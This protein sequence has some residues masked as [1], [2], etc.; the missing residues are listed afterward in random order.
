MDKSPEAF[1]TISEVADVLETPAHVLRFWES[2]FPQIRPVKRAGG[3]R[4]YRPGDVALLAGIKR[5][6]HDEGMTI[7]GV[8]KILR[9]QGIRHVASLGSGDAPA[10]LLDSDIE[11][12]LSAEY[13]PSARALS[14]HLPS[15]DA[16]QTAQII[17]L[18]TALNR[19]DPTRGA[20]PPAQGDLWPGDPEDRPQDAD[21][22]MDTAQAWPGDPGLA[23]EESTAEA[24]GEPDPLL[25]PDGDAPSEA[26]PADPPQTADAAAMPGDAAHAGD[27]LAAASVVADPA[28]LAATIAAPASDGP[29]VENPSTEAGPVESQEAGAEGAPVAESEEP[30]TTVAALLRRLPPAQAAP[31]EAELARLR[32]RLMDLRGRVAD[33]A[34]R[35]AK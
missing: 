6:L 14:D 1:R 35:R 31:V 5:L 10:V 22:A 30:T 20:A 32:V 24:A 2:R 21:A 29:R 8:Q 26:E 7:R 23:V 34:R 15:D 33:A 3:R 18:E 9:E 11:A 28:P 12:V 25:V 4:Y 13:G 27:G 16:L 17:S 19:Q